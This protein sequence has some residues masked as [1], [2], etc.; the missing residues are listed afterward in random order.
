MKLFIFLGLCF[1]VGCTLAADSSE[2]SDEV[3]NSTTSSNEAN[4]V[5]LQN[6]EE[7]SKV[8]P[9][10]ESIVS[11]FDEGPAMS[12]PE[13][14]GDAFQGDMILT[15]EQRQEMFDTSIVE[16]RTGLLADKYR[17]PKNSN[18]KPIVPYVIDNRFC[19]L[20]FRWFLNEKFNRNIFSQKLLLKI[21]KSRKQ[22]GISRKCHVC[23]SRQEKLKRTTSTFNR[24]AKAVTRK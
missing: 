6:S 11:R 5:V 7:A 24:P 14:Q 3:A 8:E 9:L 13:E 1:L 20:L 19:K 2:D 4:F 22:C 16:S 12:I 23:A 21:K 17:W 10:E 15:E 18:G